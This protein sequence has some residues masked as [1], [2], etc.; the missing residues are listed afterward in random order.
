MRHRV[1]LAH[2]HGL[3][4][5]RVEVDRDA[6]RRADLVLAAVAAADRLGVVEV[7][8]P[9]LAQ[10]GRDL[11]RLRG[12]VGVARQ[13]QHRDLERRQPR[14]ELQHHADVGAALGVRHLFLDVGVHQE[15]HHRPADTGRRL[16]DERPVPLARGLVE[17][18]QVLARVVRVRRQVEVG[19][20]RD[21]LELAPLLTGV[22]REPVL[23][24]DGALRVVRELFLRVLVVAQV[25]GLDAE[26][27]VPLRALVDPVLVPA[28]VLA[29]LDEELHLHLLELARPEDEVARRDLVAEG[30]ADLADAER[31]LLPRRRLDVGEVHEDALRGLRAEVVQALFG[32][33]RAEVGLQHHVEVPRRGV[34][35]AR[36]AVRARHLGQVV[37]AGLLA[38]ARRELLGELV[39][40][41]ALVARQA[42][43]QRVGEHVDVPGRDPDLP[44]QDH[45]GVEADDVVTAL[46]DGLP[47]LALDVV[48][49][50]DPERPVVPR[51]AGAAVDLSAGE[52]ETTALAQAD[53]LLNGVRGHST[54]RKACGDGSG[55]E[56]P[57][58]RPG[59]TAFRAGEPTAAT[60]ATP[61]RRGC[62][63]S[64]RCRRRTRRRR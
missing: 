58:Y 6:V 10:G 46:D 33:H 30:L 25:V 11:L 50:L 32:L 38:G 36:A 55:L 14:V 47:P 34:L 15:R 13:R 19:A 17:E 8:V 44:R 1:A 51:R 29:R 9:V 21:A 20:V 42:L 16:D 49:E 64:P 43:D 60:P 40:A 18:R 35:A 23:D 4:L 45:R 28:L 27:R 61:S 37:L 26:V 41:E 48:L 22:E 62:P 7:D 31:R 24:V 39:G 2:R 63:R 53:D 52:D 56:R 59:P 3:V 57:G 5:E 12:Q 54:L